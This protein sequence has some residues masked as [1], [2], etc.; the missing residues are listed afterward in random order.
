L[1]LIHHATI[2]GGDREAELALALCLRVF[3]T[4]ATSDVATEGRLPNLLLDELLVLFVLLD[5]LLEQLPQ[6]CV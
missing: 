3:A 4:S 2:L 6:I 5:V 1:L